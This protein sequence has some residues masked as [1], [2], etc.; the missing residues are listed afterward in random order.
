MMVNCHANYSELISLQP[1]PQG[2]FPWKWR[3][4]LGKGKALSKKLISS[5]TIPQLLEMLW[6]SPY[7]SEKIH[8]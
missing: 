5:I 1:L 2:F 4:F 7:L 3:D 6:K 8:F